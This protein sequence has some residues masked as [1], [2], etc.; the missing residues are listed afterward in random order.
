MS[1]LPL[2]WRRDRQFNFGDRI[3]PWLLEGLTGTPSVWANVDSAVPY[4]A[5]V[6][7]FLEIVSDR[8]HVWGTG[9]LHSSH[10]PQPAAHYHAVRG[11]LT[12]QKILSA[13]GSCPEIYGDPV[14]LL[15]ELAPLSLSPKY[16]GIIPQWREAKAGC[17]QIV[18]DPR[19]TLLDITAP[20]QQFLT[21][22]S[23]CRAI[24]SGSLHGLIAAHAYGIPAMWIQPTSKPLG[25]GFKFRDYL[26]SVG[27]SVERGATFDSEADLLRLADSARQVKFDLQPFREAFPGKQFGVTLVGQDKRANIGA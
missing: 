20:R 26:A 12:R 11:P 18:R 15:P 7:S 13:G 5:L 21:Q 25:D 27:Q 3:S 6:G 22:L 8:A 14:Q 2:H 17:Y 1:T 19:L 16:V 23:E 4:L 10:R 9:L 24:L